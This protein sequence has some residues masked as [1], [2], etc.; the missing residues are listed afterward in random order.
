MHKKL[1][2]YTLVHPALLKRNG[3]MLY[4]KVM[5]IMN[6]T[7]KILF[8]QDGKNKGKKAKFITVVII[9]IMVT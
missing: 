8:L 3:S 6:R 2:K 7:S 9:V 4:Q 1:K 5:Y